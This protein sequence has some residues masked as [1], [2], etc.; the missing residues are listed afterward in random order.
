MPQRLSTPLVLVGIAAAVG[1]AA[2]GLGSTVLLI[3][4]GTIRPEGKQGPPGPPGERGERGSV[5]PEVRVCLCTKTR[6]FF[7]VMA[8]ELAHRRDELAAFRLLM[9]FSGDLLPVYETE[10]HRFESCRARLFEARC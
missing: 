6:R 3:Q 8:R 1:G 7:R 10:G 4:T 5:G 9:G 2:L